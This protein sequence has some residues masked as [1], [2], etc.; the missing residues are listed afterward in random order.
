MNCKGFRRKRSW[1]NFTVLS[2]HLSG[3][4][5]EYQEIPQDNLSLGQ[6][7]NPGLS[8]YVSGVLT[9]RPR[10]S[11]ALL[12]DESNILSAD[13]MDSVTK[14]MTRIRAAPVSMS[15]GEHICPR[16]LDNL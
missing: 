5:E 8:D 12:T 10:L 13:E 2:R 7:L 15:R 11:V 14:Q 4:I 1:P 16:Y 6:D 3:G 9:T